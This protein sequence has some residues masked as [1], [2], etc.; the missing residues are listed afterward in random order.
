MTH[1]QLKLLVMHVLVEDGMEDLFDDF[2]IDNTASGM[3]MFAIDVVPSNATMS[4]NAV[5]RLRPGGYLSI[6]YAP[7]H[8][9]RKELRNARRNTDAWVF[10]P[11]ADKWNAEHGHVGGSDVD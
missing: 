10:S 8:A 4:P 5:G 6:E 3:L 2:T 7:R 11:A 9:R 1:A